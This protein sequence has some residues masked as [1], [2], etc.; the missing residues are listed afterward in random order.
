MPK[1]KKNQI[2]PVIREIEERDDLEEKGKL[3]E[4]FLKRLKKLPK[5]NHHERGICYYYILRLI[6]KTHQHYESPK[7][8]RYYKK[9]QHEFRKQH[10]IHR[11]KTKKKRFLHKGTKT[12]IGNFYRLMERFFSS[13]EVLYDKKDFLEAVRRAYEEKMYYRKYNFKFQKKRWR[14]WEYAFLDATCKYGDSF[15]RWG[16]TSLTFGIVMGGVYWVTDVA[17]ANEALKL[18]G[19]S[20]HWYDYFY[21]SLVTL[22]SLG[23]GDITPVSFMGKFLSM[24]E[25]FFGFI[26]LGVFVNLIQKKL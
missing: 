7:A 12:H 21:F 17:Q 20:G 10:K 15:F 25:V 9:M 16:L 1:R 18:V 13:L 3:Q 8:I 6:L 22:T 26:M 24:I 11:E 23:Y 14:Y 4:L 19:E 2:D 5:S